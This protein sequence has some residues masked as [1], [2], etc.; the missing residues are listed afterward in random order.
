MYLFVFFGAS[1]YMACE[2][3]DNLGIG[4]NE[5]VGVYLFL[6]NS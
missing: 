2:K 4:S 3:V 1:N 6:L 5:V